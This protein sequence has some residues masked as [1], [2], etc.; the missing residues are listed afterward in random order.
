MPRKSPEYRA[1]NTSESDDNVNVA[2]TEKEETIEPVQVAEIEVLKESENIT[3]D[4]KTSKVFKFIRKKVLPAVIEGTSQTVGAFNNG[5]D[6]AAKTLNKVIP[7]VSEV[8]ID[9]LYQKI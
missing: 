3:Q 4:S 8:A 1:V 2:E 7:G 6:Y 5:V 9:F